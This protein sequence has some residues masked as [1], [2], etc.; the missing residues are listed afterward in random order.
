M[1]KPYSQMVKKPREAGLFQWSRGKDL[2]R[3]AAWPG[4]GSA[5]KTGAARRRISTWGSI[6]THALQVLLQTRD[7]KTPHHPV[8]CFSMVAGEGLEPTTS[9]L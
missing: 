7:R 6:H 3:A 5:H 8:G 9:G 4:L 1:E 2:I